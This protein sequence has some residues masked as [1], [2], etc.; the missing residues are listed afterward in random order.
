MTRTAIHIGTFRE[1]CTSHGCNGC[2]QQM[3]VKDAAALAE[4]HTARGDHAKA[5]AVYAAIAKSYADGGDLANE[6]DR[7]AFL[8][9]TTLAVAA[10]PWVSAYAPE[11]TRL[12]WSY[13]GEVQTGTVADLARWALDCKYGSEYEPIPSHVY[14]GS[15]TGGMVTVPVRVECTPF[16]GSDYA[17]LTV[18]VELTPEVTV[19]AS[20]TVDGRA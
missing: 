8:A 20:R 14:V 16:D 13:D 10:G 2:P 6:G 3:T 12:A 7:L 1:S 15:E 5:A 9:A 11:D 19:S 17:T 4:R 18:S